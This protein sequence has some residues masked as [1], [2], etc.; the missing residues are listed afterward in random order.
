[1]SKKRVLNII[2]ALIVFMLLPVSVLAT[3]GNE[4]DPFTDTSDTDN[5]PA[6]PDSGSVLLD[7]TA[8][9]VPVEAGESTHAKVTLN[10]KSVVKKSGV[11]VVLVLDTSGSMGDG[12][13]SQ[14]S[15]CLNWAHYETFSFT[16]EVSYYLYR[17]GRAV[18][19]N[20][21][22]I[23]V[24]LR[25]HFRSGDTNPEIVSYTVSGLETV[26]NGLP[27]E[28]YYSRGIESDLYSFTL[29][30]LQDNENTIVK[31]WL[32]ATTEFGG[33]T[34]TH[35]S[36]TVTFP[37]GDG[38]VGKLATYHSDNLYDAAY[39]CRF[40]IDV[41]KEAGEAFVDTFF[42]TE[43]NENRL[44]VITFA[45]T[46]TQVNG[47]QFYTG[48]GTDQ[49][50]IKNALEN[51]Y[52]AGNT[53]YVKPL[54][55]AKEILDSRADKTR[56]SY[57]VFVSDG[58]PF[59]TDPSKTDT[60]N[61]II[62]AVNALSAVAEGI[63]SVGINLEGS[64]ALDI[65]Q[66]VVK[67]P[68]TN[69]NIRDSSN[70]L[71]D[72]F[73]RIAGETAKTSNKATITDTMGNVFNL[74]PD[75]NEYPWM[76]TIN[77][78]AVDTS[79]VT[80]DGDTLTWNLGDIPG[81]AV[82]TYYITIKSDAP[83]GYYHDTNEYAQVTYQNYLGNWCK[84]EFPVPKLYYPVPKLEPGSSTD[85]SESSVDP[86]P[87]SSIDPNPNS[88]IDPNPN[89]STGS[90]QNPEMGSNDL[91]KEIFVVLIMGFLTVVAAFGLR[92]RQEH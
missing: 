79:D 67:T 5:F 80:S 54:N 70:S 46:V 57:V 71:K 83:Q 13:S 63:Y 72:I 30:D 27:I 31:Q 85:E 19:I 50:A 39:G 24:D 26:Y 25:V 84:Q 18:R 42:E 59:N 62:S 41:L 6:Y 11:D 73:V 91:P 28:K 81:E 87:E 20:N 43:G 74:V 2:L 64:K 35:D 1:M 51:I 10:L 45:D 33:M 60:K 58:E 56:T 3:K 61:Q 22:E 36:C 76:L 47:G 12:G 66:T 37:K 53:S 68:G 44:S 88:S 32:C 29:K 16:K 21:D 82:F 23:T 52:P 48:S 69:I 34:Q 14:Y 92:K 77:G 78:V 49:D 17:D 55:A 90:E 75:S 86:N 15:P 38:E 8:E 40:R 65:I 89:S 4:D 7:K 9:W